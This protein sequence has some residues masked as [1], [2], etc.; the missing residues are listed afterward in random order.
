MLNAL[1]KISPLRQR[2]QPQRTY[3]GP[4]K[5]GQILTWGLQ[6]AFGK[7]SWNFAH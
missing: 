4:G 5:C 6:I 2:Y 1:I 7:D 3:Q